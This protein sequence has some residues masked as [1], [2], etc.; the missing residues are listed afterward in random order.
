MSVSPAML[1]GLI[2]AA[3]AAGLVDSIAGGGGLVTVPALLASGLPPHVVLGTNKGQAVFGAVSSA[4]SFHRRGRVDRTRMVPALFGGA[5][6]SAL[7]AGLLLLV[8]PEP[9]RPVVMVLLVGAALFMALKRDLT[10]SPKRVARPFLVTFA[11]GLVLGTYDGFFG[12][13]VGSLY[14]I[15]LV[16]VFGD[17]L[18]DASGNAKMLNLGSNLSAVLVLALAHKVVWSLSLPMAVGNACGAALGSRLAIRGGDKFVRVVVL[19]V[20]I[21]VVVKVG[22]DVARS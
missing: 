9:L 4:V 1:I 2:L 21:A 3:F 22:F 15:A 20:V 6:G 7:G 10:P 14:I 12:P 19:L 5:V 13:G 17:G 18:T 8:R 16:T 11:I